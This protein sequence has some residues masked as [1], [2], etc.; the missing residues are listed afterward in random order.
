MAASS[1]FFSQA[2]WPELYSSRKGQEVQRNSVIALH[3]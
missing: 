2:L 3:P 1:T